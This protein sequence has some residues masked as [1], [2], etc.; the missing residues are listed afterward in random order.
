MF[1]TNRLWW[2]QPALITQRSWACHNRSL[3]HLRLTRHR[4]LHCK[5]VFSAITSTV[6]LLSSVPLCLFI[7]HNIAC[8]TH[9]LGRS[10]IDTITLRT[11]LIAIENHGPAP[12]FQLLPASS[13]LSSVLHMNYTPKGAQMKH[14]RLAAVPS[15]KGHLASDAFCWTVVE[16]VDCRGNGLSPENS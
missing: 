10:I 14:G 13:G 3:G 7:K 4:V 2:L 12:V 8:H 1:S 9:T 15:F 6:L 11:F 16:N 5:C